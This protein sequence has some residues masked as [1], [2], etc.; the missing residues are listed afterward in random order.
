METEKR[1]EKKNKKKKS[2]KIEVSVK[3]KTL[4]IV[5][6]VIVTVIAIVSFSIGISQWVK[7]EPGYYDI[8]AS[9]DDLVPGYAN[10]ITLTC[11]FD[12]K[13]DEIRVKNNNATTAYSNG[14]KWIYCMVDAET[15]YDG[16][17]NIAMLNQHM[18]EDIS[19]SSELFNILTDAY[20]FTCRGTGYNMFV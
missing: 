15:N 5:C 1:K 9:A 3:H 20:E 10:G 7:K 18:G 14:L 2:E 19:V 4:R 16:Y 8:K 6:F 11:Y 13:S 17:N 12:G